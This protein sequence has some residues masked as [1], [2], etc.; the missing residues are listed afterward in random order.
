[1]NVIYIELKGGIMK[2]AVCCFIAVLLAAILFGSC[3]RADTAQIDAENFLA[4]LESGNF[5][6]EEITNEFPYF[7]EMEDSDGNSVMIWQKLDQEGYAIHKVEVTVAG[8]RLIRYSYIDYETISLSLDSKLTPEGGEELAIRFVREFRPDLADLT[9]ENKEWYLSRYDP[10]TIEAWVADDGI[11]R[12][13]VM[14]DLNAGIVV[15]FSRE[16]VLK[17]NP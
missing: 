12:Y 9:W 1:M 8:T 3:T 17:L 10:D 15:H 13:G 5:L 16:D 14:V 11:F 7:R 6:W 2:K 4:R